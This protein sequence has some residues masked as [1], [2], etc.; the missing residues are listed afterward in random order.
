MQDAH[1]LPPSYTRLSIDTRDFRT[2]SAAALFQ[3]LGVLHVQ[4]AIPLETLAAI[5]AEILD[6][7]AWL[8][9]QVGERVPYITV[10]RSEFDPAMR[11]TYER[12]VMLLNEV[13]S[14]Q[15][16]YRDSI[17]AA[18]GCSEIK[19]I[20]AYAREARN[21]GGASAHVGFHQDYPTFNKVSNI[22]DHFK[23][24][25]TVTCWIPLGEIDDETPSIEYLP[26]WLNQ[27]LPSN[28]QGTLDLEVFGET[29]DRLP[30]WVPP[31]QL[32]DFIIHDQFTLH[33]SHVTPKRTKQRRSF[34][35][36]LVM[37]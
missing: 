19:Y 27:E 36:R 15:F 16:P 13:L 8:E 34:E 9:N 14:P 18:A 29:L 21:D 28:A 17:A 30:H 25:R 7:L 33:R 6:G 26:A 5:K 4:N 1:Q 22:Q 24:K 23:P 20:M 11:T 3:G 31:V 35:L 10:M 2:A 32:G 12:L 37:R